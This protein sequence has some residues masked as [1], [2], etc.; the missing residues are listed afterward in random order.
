MKDIIFSVGVLILQDKKVML[1]RHGEDAGHINGTYGLPAGR[2]EKDE[3][4]RTAAVR[5][6]KEETGLNVLPE[7][8][9]EYPS[10][11][12]TADI[13]R[14]DGKTSTFQIKV[15]VAKHFSGVLTAGGETTPEWVE[16][17]KLDEYNLLPNV[18]EIVLREVRW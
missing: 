12:W 15:F 10:D 6:L 7:D 11:V 8:L 14:K 3:N 18:K 16:I 5:E 4:E 9:I 17:E 1:V 2:L 13:K